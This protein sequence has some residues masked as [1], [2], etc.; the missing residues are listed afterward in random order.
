MKLTEETGPD[1]T[2]DRI[3]QIFIDW[4][5]ILPCKHAVS[6]PLTLY[7]EIP[8]YQCFLMRC[9]LPVNEIPRDEKSSSFTLCVPP[10]LK[11]CML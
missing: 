3:G 11:K 9:L 8:F 2:V 7:C 6:T 1:G 10:F 5:C 4:V